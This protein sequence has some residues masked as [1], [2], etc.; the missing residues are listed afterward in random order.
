[1][2]RF[3]MNA[4]KGQIIDH[5]NGNG[6]DN[7]KENLR[8]CTHRQNA[9][10][11]ITGTNKTSKYKG[12]HL[13]KNNGLWCVQIKIPNKRIRLGNFERE[14]D[15]ALAYNEAAIKYFGEFACLNKIVNPQTTGE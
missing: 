5:I 14:D 4:Q 1:M 10:N 12:V 7:R 9:Y 2:H 11:L 8:F 15:A 6:L 13:L 3:I